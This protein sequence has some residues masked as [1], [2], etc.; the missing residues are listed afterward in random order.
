LAG[1][2]LRPEFHRKLI[3]SRGVNRVLNER[4]R[5]QFRRG[6]TFATVVPMK[7]PNR[8]NRHNPH[9]RKRQRFGKMSSK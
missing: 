5:A 4:P 2:G 6:A 7:P 1:V 8:H 9:W 3:F